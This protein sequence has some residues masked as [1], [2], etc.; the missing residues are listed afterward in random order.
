MAAINDVG[1]K[2]SSPPKTQAP[3]PKPQ[4]NSTN[5]TGQTGGNNKPDDVK[6][7]NLPPE[8][9][10]ELSVEAQ[11]AV[12]GN[13]ELPENIPI[14]APKTTSNVPDCSQE[15]CAEWVQRVFR[16]N[17]RPLPVGGNAED[18][19]PKD[20]G[21]GYQ[22]QSNGQPGLS[23]QAGDVLCWGDGGTQN[24]QWGHVA[25]IKETHTDP[26]PPYVVVA[27]AN[28]GTNDGQNV[29]TRQIPY[30]PATNTIQQTGHCPVQGWVHPE[31]DNSLVNA[32]PGQAGNYVPQSQ[33]PA[34]APG[35]GTPQ[36]GASGTQG[37]TPQAGDPGGVPGDTGG[38]VNGNLPGI[39]GD[40]PVMSPTGV[41][42]TQSV[43]NMVMSAWQEIMMGNFNG[44]SVQKLYDWYMK[45]DKNSQDPIRQMAGNIL[46]MAGMI[47]PQNGQ[48]PVGG[49]PPHIA[50]MMQ[51]QQ[52]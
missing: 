45:G 44:P 31:G 4:T 14:S 21:E 24:S 3:A 39:F 16:E 7:A 22:K 12:S 29:P 37:G 35:G 19:F 10:A 15:Q 30:D 32:P 25:I 34:S 52:M 1:S 36:T 9:K 27:E 40:N 6:T 11:K 20:W 49:I 8:D 51:A 26:P 43:G 50:R 47:V 48:N 42:I 46:Q 33:M 28:Y 5:T 38:Q 23:P 13:T 2:P 41:E 18:L 17:G